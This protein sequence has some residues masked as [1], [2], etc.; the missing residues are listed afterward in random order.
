MVKA[1][2]ALLFGFGFACNLLVFSL[3]WIGGALPAVTEGVP[4]WQTLFLGGS[5]LVLS[6]G[7]RVTGQIELYRIIYT[8]TLSSVWASMF[9]YLAAQFTDVHLFHFWK[10]PTGPTPAAT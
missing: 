7:E 10:K 3:M 4:P 2:P 5:E 8:C 9:A 1:E 6:S